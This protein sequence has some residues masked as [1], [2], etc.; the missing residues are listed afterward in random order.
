[1]LAGAAAGTGARLVTIA[2]EPEGKEFIVVLFV[3]LVSQADGEALDEIIATFRVL[4]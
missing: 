3:Q 4:V 1:V 2:A